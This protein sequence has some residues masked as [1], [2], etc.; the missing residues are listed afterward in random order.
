MNHDYE[1]FL[2]L[3][4]LKPFAACC[5]IVSIFVLCSKRAFQ[6]WKPTFLNNSMQIIIS[7]LSSVV[8]ATVRYSS[9]GSKGTL[10]MLL[11]CLIVNVLC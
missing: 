11:C 2:P 4:V 9:A 3:G 8:K 5:D 10:S 1:F 6:Y 7:A